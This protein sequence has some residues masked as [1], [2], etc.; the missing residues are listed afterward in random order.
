MSNL[1][2]K[3]FQDRA[4][5]DQIIDWFATEPAVRRK[6]FLY[7]FEAMGLDSAGKELLSVLAKLDHELTYIKGEK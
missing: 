3:D 1:F 2:D 7:R 5:L 4:S 6:D